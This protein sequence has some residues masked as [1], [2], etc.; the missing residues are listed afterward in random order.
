VAL[1]HITESG[2]AVASVLPTRW[3][4]VVWQLGFALFYFV[5]GTILIHKLLTRD[6]VTGHRPVMY[7]SFTALML[8]LG[9]VHFSIARLAL[10]A[11]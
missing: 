6:A 1:D 4:T 11:R 2:D 8:F 10:K 7:T 3:R 9:V 5:A